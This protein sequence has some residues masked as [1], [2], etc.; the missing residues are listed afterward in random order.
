MPSTM[1]KGWSF[2]ATTCFHYI[3]LQITSL[4]EC[5]PYIRLVNGYGHFVPYGSD[6]ALTSIWCS[7]NDTRAGSSFRK[8]IFIKGCTW[9]KSTFTF[10]YRV[11]LTLKEMYNTPRRNNIRNKEAKK[12]GKRGKKGEKVFTTMW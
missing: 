9:E 4:N 11:A 3:L 1:N 8:M 12:R 2:I 6:V 7:D 10:L 5:V